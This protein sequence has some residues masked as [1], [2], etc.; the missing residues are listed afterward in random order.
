MLTLERRP[1]AAA[2][3][4]ELDASSAAPM[5]ISVRRAPTSCAGPEVVDVSGL[6]NAQTG[7]LE[8]SLP[9]QFVLMKWSPAGGPAGSTARSANTNVAVRSISNQ[10][11]G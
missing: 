10:C 11:F 6:L 3:I 5:N 1:P 2:A 8:Q 4:E 9:I 7:R